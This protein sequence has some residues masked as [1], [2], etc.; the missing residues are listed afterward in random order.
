[1]AVYEMFKTEKPSILGRFFILFKI[2]KFI[3][4]LENQ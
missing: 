3:S 1:M 2:R 4:I